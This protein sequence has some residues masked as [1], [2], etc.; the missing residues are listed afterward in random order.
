[1]AKNRSYTVK[2]KRKRNKKTDYNLRLKLIK[3]GKQRLLIRKSLKNILIQVVK[4]EDSR[5]KVVISCHSREL[6]KF[7]WG[8][9]LGNIP[10]AY[11]T[12]FLF[13]KKALKKG[14]KEAILDLGLQKSVVKSRLYSALKG[15]IDVGLNVPHNPKIFPNEER[16]KGSH[17]NNE[18]KNK[19]EEVKKKIE[20]G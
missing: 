3:S 1:M 5:D 8:Y 15:C 9:N 7:G 18:I 6:K 10:S 20:N 4:S 17:I 2:V 19:F 16:I 13:G 11:L 14:V 12:G